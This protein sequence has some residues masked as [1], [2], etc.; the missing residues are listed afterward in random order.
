MVD[1]NPYET[2][3]IIYLFSSSLS[4]LAI[5]GYQERW[6]GIL[7]TVFSF[8]L[9]MVSMFDPALYSPDKA[10]FY[11]ISNFFIVLLVGALILVFYDRLA[12]E[13][14][15]KIIQQ[16]KALVKTNA[17]LDR[18]V[19][20]VSH[21][22]RAPL[23]SILGLINVY[24]LAANEQEKDNLV[25]LMQ[26]RVMKLDAFIQ[27]I[28]DYSRNARMALARENIMLEEFLNSQVEGL[29]FIAGTERIKI[30][31]Q[32]PPAFQVCS[33]PQRLKVIVNNLLSNSVRYADLQKTNPSIAIE[34]GAET[35]GWSIRVRD[36]GIGIKKEAQHK[37]FEMFYQATNH[38]EGS[39]LGLYIVKEAVQV[40]DG[41]INL[42]STYGEGTEITVTFKH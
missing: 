24:A 23:A 6:K 29:Q 20:S 31:V 14:E 19:Y 2:A 39:G 42:Q 38:A 32:V 18:F 8:V 3:P 9:F 5:F 30:A 10:H 35:D 40:L 33:D 26:G 36:N 15:K 27:E 28:L 4:A 22:L 16:N 34:A 41:K 21:D 11:F 12:F 37:V 17:E 13:S 1:E 25:Q 7:F